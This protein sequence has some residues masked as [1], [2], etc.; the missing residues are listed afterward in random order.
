MVKESSDSNGIKDVPNGICAD[1]AHDLEGNDQSGYYR[2][3]L[4]DLFK[5]IDSWVVKEPN[6]GP[7]VK[8]DCLDY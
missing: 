8:P 1:F 7:G 6:E 5:L 2:V 3:G 4:N